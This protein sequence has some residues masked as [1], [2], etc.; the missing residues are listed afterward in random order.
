MESNVVIDIPGAFVTKC[1]AKGLHAVLKDCSFNRG[2]NNLFSMSKVLHTQGWK[3][4]LGD[5]SLICIKNDK[6]GVINF[7]IVVATEAHN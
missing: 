5:K 1:R 2:H 4:M 7:D 3:I 6:S